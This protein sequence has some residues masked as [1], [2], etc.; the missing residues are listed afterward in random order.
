MNIASLDTS[1]APETLFDHVT[2]DGLAA[3]VASVYASF[4]HY[5]DFDLES[6]TTNAHNCRKSAILSMLLIK[7]KLL[8]SLYDEEYIN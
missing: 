8:M 2:Q 1:G 6:K 3:G 4:R 5:K 7:N